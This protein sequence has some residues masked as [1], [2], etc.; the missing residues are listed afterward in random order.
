MTGVIA[1]RISAVHRSSRL[2]IY[3]FPDQA[4]IQWLRVCRPGHGLWSL[5]AVPLMY[6]QKKIGYG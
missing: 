3:H 6:V 2:T 5:P 1:R 4:S